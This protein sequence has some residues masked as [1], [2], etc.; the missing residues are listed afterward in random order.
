MDGSQIK[1]CRKSLV[2]PGSTPGFTAQDSITSCQV[3]KETLSNLIIR[4]DKRVHNGERWTSIMARV[5]LISARCEIPDIVPRHI[6]S[7]FSP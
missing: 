5:S 4:S 6:G 3:V 7:V 1:T 2:S